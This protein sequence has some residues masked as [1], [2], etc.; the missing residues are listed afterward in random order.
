MKNTIKNKTVMGRDNIRFILFLI[1][2][3][4]VITGLLLVWFEIK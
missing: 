1:L 3:L 2:S 4:P